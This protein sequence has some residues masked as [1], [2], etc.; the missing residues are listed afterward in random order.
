MATTLSSLSIW[1]I[2][3][4]EGDRAT[5]RFFAAAVP[6]AYWALFFAAAGRFIDRRSAAGSG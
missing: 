1:S 4:G 3:F 5:V 2:W 6:V